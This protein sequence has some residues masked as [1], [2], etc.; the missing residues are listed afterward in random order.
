MIKKYFIVIKR[1]KYYLT[2]SLLKILVLAAVIFS[3]TFCFLLFSMLNKMEDR[4]INQLGSDVLLVSKDCE[5]D[6]EA[7]LF[8]NKPIKNYFNADDALK[9]IKTE[10]VIKLSSQLYTETIANGCCTVN[11]DAR[12]IGFDHATDFVISPWSSNSVSI[13]DDEVIIGSNIDAFKDQTIKI[14]GRKF[15]VK[16][17]L[18][19]VGSGIDDAMFINLNVAKSI[20]G[21]SGEQKVASAIYIKLKDG[22]NVDDWVK[23]INESN[24]YV[25]AF[26]SSSTIR[27]I[28]KNLK[29]LINLI[30]I[31]LIIFSGIILCIGGLLI[32]S[33][34]KIKD[35]ER[36]VFKIMGYSKKAFFE[37][38]IYEFLQLI[39][40]SLCINVAMFMFLN[41][42]FQ[43]YVYDVIGINFN[44]IGMGYILLLIFKA[45][46][47]V[48]IIGIISESI[49]FL[50]DKKFKKVGL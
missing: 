6:D 13:E 23:N 12:V 37:C 17:V 7:F 26:S 10:D 4:A 9:I 50:L 32:N 35:R 41:M 28:E 20:K 29:N 38:N 33:E 15:R 47:L 14:R 39:F 16:L 24:N 46:F 18:D 48:M 43:E 31:I 42:V 5:V 40:F 21:I 34:N 36:N 8:T 19:K 44:N 45:S 27:S 2:Y 25:R 22:V 3:I 30:V 11:T 49:K 1:I